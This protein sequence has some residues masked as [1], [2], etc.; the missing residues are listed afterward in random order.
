MTAQRPTIRTL[1]MD[2]TSP[3][4]PTRARRRDALSV[5]CVL[6][7]PWL[8]RPAPAGISNACDS[9]T[10]SAR[11]YPAVTADR[12]GPGHGARRAPQWDSRSHLRRCTMSALAALKQW[13][14]V[15][16]HTTSWSSSTR[17][18]GRSGPRSREDRW[19]HDLVLVVPS[20]QTHT[21]QTCQQSGHAGRSSPR[22]SRTRCAP[23]ARTRCSSCG[24]PAPPFER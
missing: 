16:G 23:S 7:A 19:K 6:R 1:A 10:P 21:L 9:P 11:R 24:N 8:R 12:T 15:C 13:A 18:T 22:Q 5:T 20:D 17:S 4:I 14:I 2:G 3:R